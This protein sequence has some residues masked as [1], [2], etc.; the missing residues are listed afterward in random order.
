M[1]LFAIYSTSQNERPLVAA[2]E[3]ISD[4]TCANLGHIL[5]IVQI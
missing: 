2:S 3:L 1:R 4:P 5:N